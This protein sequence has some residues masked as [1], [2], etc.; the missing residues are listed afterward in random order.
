MDPSARWWATR[1]W[2]VGLAALALGTAYVIASLF[3]ESERLGFVL[4]GALVTG[5]ALVSHLKV[6]ALERAQSSR[7]LSDWELLLAER[8]EVVRIAGGVALVAVVAIG[9]ARWSAMG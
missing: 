6:V 9:V 4:F 8:C 3:S 1:I 2:Y 7:S 5:V